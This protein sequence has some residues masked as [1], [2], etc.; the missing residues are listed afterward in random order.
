MYGELEESAGME[1]VLVWLQ[2][3]F[4][5]ARIYRLQDCVAKMEIPAALGSLE[6]CRWGNKPHG[7]KDS[8]SSLRTRP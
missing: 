7:N 3:L 4:S 8:R 1:G 2:P 5:H 6:S